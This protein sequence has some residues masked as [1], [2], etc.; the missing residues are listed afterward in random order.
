[1]WN[2]RYSLAPT[3]NFPSPADVNMSV[4][5]FHMLT[6][7]VWMMMEVHYAMYGGTVNPDC[8]FPQEEQD[9]SENK[10]QN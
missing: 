7:L 1:L 8:Q 2:E 10:G 6:S 4:Q 5:I 3:S 9:A